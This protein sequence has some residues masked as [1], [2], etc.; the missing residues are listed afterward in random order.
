MV[1]MLCDKYA[2]TTLNGIV[3]NKAAIDKISEFGLKVQGGE[4]TK[5]LIIYGPTGV[6]KT[7]AAYALSYSYSFEIIELSASDYRNAERLKKIV[8]PAT[9]NRGLFNSKVLILFDEIDDL[10][11]KFDSG[12]EAAIMDIIKNSRQPIIFTAADYWDRSISFMRGSADPVEFKKVGHAEVIALLEKIV[13]QEG[14]SLERKV[15]EL[16]A[17]RCNGDVRG[18]I[19]DLEAMAGSEPELIERLGVRDAKIEVFGVLDKIFS[20]NDFDLSRNALMRSDLDLEMIVNWMEENITKRYRRKEEISSAYEQVAN[21]TRFLNKA[22]RTNYYGYLRYVQVFLSAG[23]SLS[24]MGGLT[25]LSRYSFPSTIRYLSST[26]SDRAAA[27][28]IA[29]KLS[30]QL[31]TNKKRIVS[32]Y[33]PIIKAMLKKEAAE[34]GNERAIEEAEA[35]FGLYEKEAESLLS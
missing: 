2:P 18:A 14:I 1:I 34:V 13:K 6:G 12:A 4:R 7:A 22:S 27:S 31:H 5:P 23:I 28:E 30:A 3:G 25:M 21:A 19:N 15:I 9:R 29:S 10:S 32:E 11:K 17:R 35:A 24:N 20:C 16:I 33:I 26:K 8:I